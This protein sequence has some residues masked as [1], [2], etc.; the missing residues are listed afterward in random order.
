M[1]TVVAVQQ[2]FSGL[3]NHVDGKGVIHTGVEA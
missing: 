2:L 1:A 3:S